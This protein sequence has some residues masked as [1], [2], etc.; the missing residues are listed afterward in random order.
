ME[1]LTGKLYRIKG[2]LVLDGISYDYEEFNDPNRPH[3]LRTIVF[4]RPGH[5]AVMLEFDAEKDVLQKV[6]ERALKPS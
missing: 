1:E 3:N 4:Y 5:D 6:A 2:R